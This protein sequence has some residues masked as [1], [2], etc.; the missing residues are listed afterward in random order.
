MDNKGQRRSFIIAVLIVTLVGATIGYAAL[1]TNLYINGRAG[2]SQ[3]ASW[4]IEFTNSEK[5]SGTEGAE[6]RSFEHNATT[7]EFDVLFS[8]PGDTVTY[9]VDVTNSGTIDAKLD[10]ITGVEEANNKE[11]DQIKYE[12]TG[13][14]E[15]EVLA[16]GETKS[17]DV[18]VS[19]VA[20]TDIPEGETAK[21]SAISLNYVQ[22]V[23]E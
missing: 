2:V 1:A 11:P 4:L 17:F 5:K 16:A 12:I 8:E 22:N 18:T 15:G 6:V 20:G 21:T 3:D 23:T 10:S 7:F 13:L 14:T 9:T 19:W